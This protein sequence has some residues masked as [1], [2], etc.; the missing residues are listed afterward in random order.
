M[1]ASGETPQASLPAD[2]P[3]RAADRKPLLP[4]VPRETELPGLKSRVLRGDG[5]RR[6]LGGSSD[7][8]GE[9]AAQGPGRGRGV[10][11][12]VVGVGSMRLQGSWRVWGEQ[13]G[14]AGSSGA[15]E[16]LESSPGR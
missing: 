12:R 8:V 13:G 6:E 16:H 14:E 9:G 15:P 3:A 5:G 2:F 10:R 4:R 7:G 1:R 11:V